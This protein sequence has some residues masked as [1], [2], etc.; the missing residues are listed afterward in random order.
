MKPATSH[1]GQEIQMFIL[2]HGAQLDQLAQEMGISSVGL[3]NLIHG[4]RS[5]RDETLSKLAA[6]PLMMAGGFTLRRLKAFRAMDEYEVD[7]MVLAVLEYVK[8]HGVAA[9][10]NNFFDQLQGDLRRFEPLPADAV[11]QLQQYF[12]SAQQ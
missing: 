5:F 9:L 4:R 7:E 8:R 1:L 12:E 2:R 11:W 10:P 6:T 3:S